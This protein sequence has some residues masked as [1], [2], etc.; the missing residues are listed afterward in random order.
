MAPKPPITCPTLV[1]TG[2]EDYGNSPEMSVAIATEISRA[3]LVILK[4]L[5][6]MALAENPPAVNRPVVNFLTE[7]LG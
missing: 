4:G 3:R 7:V 6:H 5:R 2:D 1:L